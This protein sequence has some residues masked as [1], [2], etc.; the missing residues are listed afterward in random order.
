MNYKLPLTAIENTFNPNKYWDFSPCPVTN[1]GDNNPM[2]VKAD[3]F[4]LCRHQG[5]ILYHAEGQPYYRLKRKIVIPFVSPHWV[6]SNGYKPV[7]CFVCEDKGFRFVID[8]NH[9]G[10]YLHAAGD[11]LM[12]V[13]NWIFVVGNCFCEAGEKGGC[14]PQPRDM[15]IPTFTEEMAKRKDFMETKLDIPETTQGR[16][17]LFKVVAKRHA[18]EYGSVYLDAIKQRGAA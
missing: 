9:M 15:T 1:K 2:G 17:D 13:P 16:F 5:E 10:F 8:H 14:L 7:R 12:P 3:D 4:E 18:E 11:R 6:N